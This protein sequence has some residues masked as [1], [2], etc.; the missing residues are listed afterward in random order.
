[1]NI[2]SHDFGTVRRPQAVGRV[3][4]EEEVVSRGEHV[5]RGGDEGMRK[6]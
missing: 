5:G 1:M 3:E 6:A 4:R 2:Q